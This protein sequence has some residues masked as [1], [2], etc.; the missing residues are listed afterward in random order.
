M[1][2]LILFTALL[3]PVL[4]YSNNNSLNKVQLF[5]EISR[6]IISNNGYKLV[7]EKSNKLKLELKRK[8]QIGTIWG[9]PDGG[10]YYYTYYYLDFNQLKNVEMENFDDEDQYFI[11][12]IIFENE[13]KNKEVD[14]NGS[15]TKEKDMSVSDSGV[16]TVA[17]SNLKEAEMLVSLVKKLKKQ[18]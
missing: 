6:L 1:R 13:I 18:L 17:F 8:S 12:D 5:N 7:T 3:I 15:V 16:F 11:V 9:D 4:I 2:K 10:G 14:E